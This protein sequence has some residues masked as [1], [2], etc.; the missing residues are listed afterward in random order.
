MIF[1]GICAIIVVLGFGYGGFLYAESLKKRTEQISAFYDSMTMLEFNVRYMNYPIREAF[2]NTGKSCMGVVKEIFEESAGI[3]AEN[4]GVSPGTAFCEAIDGK[5][6]EL[7][8]KNDEIEILEAFSKTL[9]E[10][11]VETE[12]KNINT[13]KIRLSS[14]QEKAE[15]ETAKSVKLSRSLGVLLGVFTVIVLF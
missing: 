15:E 2:L 14:A 7:K 10:G 11:D 12:V 9:G 1:R 8:L 13:V 3:L 6:D 5:R 4:Q